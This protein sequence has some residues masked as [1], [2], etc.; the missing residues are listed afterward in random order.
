MRIGLENLHF[1]ILEKDTA[2]EASYSTPERILNVAKIKIDPKVKSKS[3][4]G[5][6]RAVEIYSALGEIDIEVEIGGIKTEIL[7]KLIGAKYS[8]GI[9]TYSGTDVAPYIALGFTGLKSNGKRVFIWLYKGKL[10]IPT[11]DLKTLEDTPDFQPDTLK[12]TFTKRA[13]DGLWKAMADEDAEDF[14]AEVAT[15]WFTKV[16]ENK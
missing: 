12:G 11:E 13:K 8:K 6:N 14:E 4:F 16:Y 5:D 2:T 9:I 7:A 3:Y 15:N 1:A 10:N